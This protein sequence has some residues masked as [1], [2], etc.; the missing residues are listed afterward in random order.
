MAE[1][2][3]VRPEYT[4]LFTQIQD[5]IADSLNSD[6]QLSSTGC[7]FHPEHLLDIDFQI[8]K[9]LGQ[10]GVVGIVNTLKG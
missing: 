1:D 8:K 3:Y 2:T 5:F 10:Q 7:V 4:P 6:V 9:H